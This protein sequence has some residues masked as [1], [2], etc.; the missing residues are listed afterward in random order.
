MNKQ[1]EFL[2]LFQ[3]EICFK[4]IVMSIIMNRNHWILFII[5]KL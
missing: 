4:N 1:I 3:K 2:L 5:L